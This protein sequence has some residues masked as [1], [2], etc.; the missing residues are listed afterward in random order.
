MCTLV[1]YSERL[2]TH[3]NNAVSISYC[4]AAHPATRKIRVKPL[5]TL[6][7]TGNLPHANCRHRGAIVEG[8]LR[9]EGRHGAW[10]QDIQMGTLGTWYSGRSSVSSNCFKGYSYPNRTNT[11]LSIRADTGELGSS[12]IQ[13]ELLWGGYKRQRGRTRFRDG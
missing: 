3:F 10:Y 2:R 4:D 6:R 1:T 7:F 8:E 13:E 9:S 5:E 12:K 11:D